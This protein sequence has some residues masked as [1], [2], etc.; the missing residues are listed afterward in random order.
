ME[1]HDIYGCPARVWLNAFTHI[2]YEDEPERVRHTNNQ[3][4]RSMDI[5]YFFP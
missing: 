4:E 3:C 5:K 1:S 2:L